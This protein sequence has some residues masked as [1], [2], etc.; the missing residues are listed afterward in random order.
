MK[1]IFLLFILLNTASILGQEVFEPIDK[2][3]YSFLSRLSNKGIIEY[4]DLIKPISR[5]IIA[6][7]IHEVSL[8]DS[9]LSTVENEELLFYKKEFYSELTLETPSDRINFLID[10]SSGRYRLLSYNSKLFKLF[11]SPIF[12]FNINLKDEKKSKH[13]WS[14]ISFYGY[15]NDWLGFS[16]DFR[17]NSESGEGFDKVKKFTSEPGAVIIPRSSNKIEYSK[18]QTSITASWLW[19]SFAI[20]KDYLT[21]G[22]AESGNLVLSNKAP[23]YPFIK[24]DLYPVEWL[25]FNYF[26]GIL[27]SDVVDSSE[28]YSTLMYTPSYKE[29]I[30]YRNKY[31]ASHTLLIRPMKGLSVSFGESIIYSDKIEIAYLFPLM[32]FRAADHYLSK[33]NNSAGG[34]SQF[35]FSISSKNQLKNTHLFGTIFIDEIT[36]EDIFDSKKQRN[37]FGFQLGSQITDIPLKNLDIRLEYTKIYPFVYSHYIPTQT[38]ENSS[39]SLG[40][41]MGYNSD[42][43]Y[44]SLNYRMI[45]GLNFKLWSQFIRKGDEGFIHQ[46]YEQPQPPFLFGLISNYSY[47]GLDFKYEVLHDMFFKLNIAL[48]KVSQQQNDNSYR[49]KDYTEISTGIFY[50]L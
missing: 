45:R 36:M 10:D 16:F 2:D 34:N 9:V 19:G 13:I 20:A 5:K 40:H 15:I 11:L 27:N 46:Q 44:F 29:R 24:L 30:I 6:L 21:W 33:S 28:I 38:Y 42:L 35:F 18:V 14:G 50:G 7:K 23:T 4:E 31:F 48:N 22:Y 26:H 8:I 43:F 41:W 32:F 37:Q 49:R 3:V 25:R 1:I 47:F 17:D 39:Y 12:G